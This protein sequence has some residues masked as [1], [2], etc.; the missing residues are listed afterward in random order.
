MDLSSP[1]LADPPQAPPRAAAPRNQN[2]P[3]LGLLALLREDLRT[4][5]G[6]L[7]E[8]GFWALAVHRFGNWRL[9]VRPKLL[10]APLTLL[11]RFL[12][13]LVECLGGISLPYYVRVGRRV[14]IWHFG[15]MVLHAR[16]IGDDVQIRQNTTLGL[17]RTDR[18]EF[19]V[20]GDRVE[21][22]CGACV[23]GAVTVGA[24]SAIGANA[25]VLVD[26]PA[27]SLAVGVPAQVRPRRDLV[28][29]PG[30]RDG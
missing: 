28:A 23:L 5:G 17:S 25:V 19:P 10:R 1:P 11:Y 4:H 13:K 21:I 9:D 8:Q 30:G 20:I 7:S 15:G 6:K 26:V 24:D 2:P 29:G 27:G 18:L 22:G 12:A 3:E 14:R 16:S